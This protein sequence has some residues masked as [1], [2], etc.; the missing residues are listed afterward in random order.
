MFTITPSARGDLG[1]IPFAAERAA[2]QVS[3]VALNFGMVPSSDFEQKQRL[4]RQD[5][6]ADW[7]PVAEFIRTDEPEGRPSF[8]VILVGQ[9]RDRPSIF[10]MLRNWKQTEETPYSRDLKHALNSALVAEFGSDN[11][12]VDRLH[13]RPMW[14]I[15]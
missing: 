9:Y 11:I 14:F 1:P 8:I 2:K 10:V 15:P 13:D 5:R 12:V 7:D 4:R 6:T 3:A